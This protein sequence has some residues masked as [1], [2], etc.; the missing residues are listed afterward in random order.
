MESP[1][2]M[3]WVGNVAVPAELA[4]SV[5]DPLPAEPTIGDEGDEEEED[6]RG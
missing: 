5:C 4:K 6:R 3:L 2:W 1:S